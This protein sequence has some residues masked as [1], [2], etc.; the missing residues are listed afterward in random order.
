MNKKIGRPTTPTDKA[1]SVLVGAMFSPPEAQSTDREPTRMGQTKSQWLRDTIN[2]EINQTP[3][4]P[5]WFVSSRP[6]K[7]LI[8]MNGEKIEF[9]LSRPGI[10]VREVGRLLIRQSSKGEVAIDIVVTKTD[11]MKFVSTRYWLLPPK[12][13]QI[14]INPDQTNAKYRLLG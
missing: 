9:T 6:I 3:P 8:E 13:T 12:D 7:E 14:E 2:T 5:K 4:P 1:K 11:G 10:K